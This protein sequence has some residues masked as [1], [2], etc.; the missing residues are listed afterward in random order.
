MGSY[1]QQPIAKVEIIRVDGDISNSTTTRSYLL[2]ILVA[3][4][5]VYST[6]NLVNGHIPLSGASI[7]CFTKL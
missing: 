2:V 7:D 5:G 6:T 4:D 1:E 3:L